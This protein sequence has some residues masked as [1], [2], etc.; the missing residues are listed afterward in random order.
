MPVAPESIFVLR[1]NDIGD[2]LAATPL[3]SALKGRF[4]KARICAGIGPWNFDVLHN[5]PCVDEIIP[6]SAPW[7]NKQ[8]TR[9]PTNSL[10]GWRD[11]LGYIFRSSEAKELRKRKFSVGIDVLGS[12]QG[13]L[14]M[15]RAG[16]PFR[17]GVRGYA[18]GHS[19]C[20]RW[21]EYN[22]GTH[23]GCAALQFAEILGADSATPR[24]PEIF[25]TDCETRA[26]GELWQEK[27]PAGGFRV[28]LAPGGGFPQKC[29]P[30]ENF[31]RVAAALGARGCA[32]MIIGG[33]G[34]KK[35]AEEIVARAPGAVDL[36]GAA[37]LRQT[38]GLISQTE[39]LLCNSS[40]AMHAGAAFNKRVM[41]LLGAWFKDRDQHQRQWGYESDFLM[42]GPEPAQCDP[43]AVVRLLERRAWLPAAAIAA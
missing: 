7:H 34:D 11:S 23:V 17:L 15:L 3:F 21:I 36:A 25:L 1:N 41:V 6:V 31:A 28:I 16:I 12:P 26:A 27:F 9:F 37:T 35:L 14:L 8:T 4:P 24:K 19:A 10:A 2:L 29:W 43:E 32:V 40:M 20:H 38:F 42:L 5:N 39:V 30:P 13:S 33:R 22:P 18:G